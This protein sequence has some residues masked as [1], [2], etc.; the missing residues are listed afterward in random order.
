MD[1]DDSA[2]P[3]VSSTNRIRPEEDIPPD[4]ECAL[5][6]K[7]LLDPLSVSCGHTFC[8][9]CINRSQEYRTACPM[10]RKPVHVGGGVNVLLAN[11]I[12]ERFPNALALR[13]EERAVEL[14]DVGETRPIKTLPHVLNDEMIVPGAKRHITVSPTELLAFK[15]AMADSS[16]IIIQGRVISVVCAIDHL[17]GND[18]VVRGSYKC[19]NGVHHTTETGLTL[20][21]AEEVGDEFINETDLQNENSDIFLWWQESMD[22]IENHLKKIGESGRATFYQHH[23]RPP[24]VTPGDC[25]ASAIL[26]ASWWITGAVKG[27]DERLLT[28]NPK[29]RIES[30]LQVLRANK[31]KMVPPLNMPGGEPWAMGAKQSLILIILLAIC[32][33]LKYAGFIGSTS[34]GGRRY[35]Y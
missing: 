9:T 1:Q 25:P 24:S 8:R 30:S 20:G 16:S 2:I 13:K 14:T 11:I 33:Y 23:G 28:I 27:P 12:A 34:Y 6:L 29:L 18:V 21:D 19:K 7:L 26:R 17:H 3:A 5:C 35:H 10:C 15:E 22:I 4:F 31:N 32:C